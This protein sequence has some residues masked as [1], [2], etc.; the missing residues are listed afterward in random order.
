[1]KRRWWIAAPLAILCPYVGYLYLGR[2]RRAVGAGLLWALSAYVAYG[3]FGGLSAKPDF[4]IIIRGL[5]VVAIAIFLFDSVVIAVRSR[6]YTIKRYNK[7][8]VYLGLATIGFGV[9]IFSIALSSVGTYWMPA[10]SMMPT[11]QA[12][13]YIVADLS[14]FEAQEPS[15]G[16]VVVFY[17]RH[18]DSPYVKRLVGLPGDRIQMVDGFLHLNAEPAGLE[19]VDDCGV[20]DPRIGGTCFRETL[21][22]DIAYEI[23][24]LDQNSRFDNT[25][26]Y[27]VPPDHFF[28][29]G[30]SRDNSTDSRVKDVGYVARDEI[31]GKVTG[32]YWSNTLSRIGMN[33]D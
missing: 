30:D 5:E 7:W 32:I 17:P 16:D 3:G 23:L 2:V 6:Q 27:E 29:L 12:G 21:P 13:D 31:V 11:F 25:E 14:A 33:V 22:G 28:V 26:I 19:K 8:W 20:V 15:R 9:V 4:L 10:R 1:M 18:I 24:D